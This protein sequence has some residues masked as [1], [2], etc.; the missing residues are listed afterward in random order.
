VSGFLTHYGVRLEGPITTPTWP[1]AAKALTRLL[2]WTTASMEPGERFEAMEVFSATTGSLTLTPVLRPAA[3]A[4]TT[5]LLYTGQE[6]L[7]ACAL[8]YAPRVLAGTTYPV[9]TSGQYRHR[10]EHTEQLRAQPWPAADGVSSLLL[11]RLTVVLA[12]PVEVYEL[13][14][15][16]VSGWQLTANPAGLSLAVTYVGAT[17][18]TEAPVNTWASVSAL[19]P[20]VD[21]ELVDVELLCRFGPYNATTALTDAALLDIASL[22]LQCQR[23]FRVDQSLSSGLAIAEPS[24]TGLAALTGSLTV[25]WYT[26]REHGLLAAVRSQTPY[27]LMLEARG[28]G[29]PQP[30]WRLWCPTVHLDQVQRPWSVNAPTATI[31]FTVLAPPSVPTW[32]APVRY[33]A[34]L[35]LELLNSTA[36]HPLVGA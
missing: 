11:R 3:V 27:T 18:A 23:P 26:A 31:P 34:R 36:T 17:M 33:D 19:L 24:C 29:S 28:P 21:V 9:P 20:P 35:V 25:P 22:T 13:S 16:M 4:V 5:P 6:T 8:G 12:T 32:L 10:L 1:T 7:L 14:S 30:L 2:P 15:A